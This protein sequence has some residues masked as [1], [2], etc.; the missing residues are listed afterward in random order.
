MRC[1]KI[2]FNFNTTVSYKHSTTTTETEYLSLLPSVIPLQRTLSVA[3]LRLTTSSRPS[4]PPSGS[5]K[6]LRFGH[7]P[8]LCTINI[9]LLTYLL[10]YKT[11]KDAVM[12]W[13]SILIDRRH[14][15]D[16]SV[17]QSVVVDNRQL[18]IIPPRCQMR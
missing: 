9:Y 8:T 4:V 17:R 15:V 5:P 10:T 16:Q 11:T 18:S 6:C 14:S 7:W 13:S 1:P 3:F 2:L 12:R